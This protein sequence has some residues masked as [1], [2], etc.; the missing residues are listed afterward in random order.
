LLHLPL[1]LAALAGRFTVGA[2]LFKLLAVVPVPPWLRRA[3]SVVPRCVEFASARSSP[4]SMAGSL[5]LGPS[6]QRTLSLLAADAGGR[7]AR[8]L[9][10]LGLALSRV[11]SFLPACSLGSLG[12][13]PHRIVD[14]CNSCLA[15]GF[16][17]CRFPIRHGH[18]VGCSYPR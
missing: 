6:F 5:R 2:L 7:T 4:S 16:A 15:I 8:L 18:P 12:F 11:T 14:L 9:S 1:V 10:L 3:R 17:G 13:N